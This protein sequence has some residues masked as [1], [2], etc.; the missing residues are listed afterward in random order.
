LEWAVPQPHNIF[1][2]FWLQAGLLGFAGFLMLLF[3]IFN[4]LFRILQDKKNATLAAPLLGFFLYVVLHGLID[5]TFWKNDLAF[6]F[7]VCAFLVLFLH[8]NAGQKTLLR[9]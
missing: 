4:A 8:A 5:T 7:W 6:L 1:L 2:A 3:F 9:T